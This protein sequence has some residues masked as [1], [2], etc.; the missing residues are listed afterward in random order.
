MIVLLLSRTMKVRSVGLLSVT[1][2]AIWSKLGR[3]KDFEKAKRVC[4]VSVKCAR[5]LKLGSALI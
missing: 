5:M 1:L 2:V 3:A 4:S